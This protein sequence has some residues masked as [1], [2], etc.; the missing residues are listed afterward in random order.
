MSVISIYCLAA[1][2]V[3]DSA[4][5]KIIFVTVSL[6]YVVIAEGMGN[7]LMCLCVVAEVIA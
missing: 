3:H 6:K 7:N 1:L 5:V 2:S 4:T